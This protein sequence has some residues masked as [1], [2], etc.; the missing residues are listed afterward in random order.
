MEE[1]INPISATTNHN[2]NNSKDDDDDSTGDIS[3]SPPKSSATTIPSNSSYPLPAYLNFIPGG[4]EYKSSTDGSKNNEKD[5]YYSLSSCDMQA[6]IQRAVAA[7][8]QLFKMN[9]QQL[10]KQPDDNNDTKDVYYLPSLSILTE[11]V[12]GRLTG[13][14][15]AN[16][17]KWA[18]ALVLAYATVDGSHHCNNAVQWCR[19][20][21]SEKEVP[22]TTAR[23]RPCGYVFK[24]GDIAWNCRTC[25]ADNTCVICDE[26]FR[27]SDHEGHEVFFHRTQPGGCCD[28]G[29]IEA[30]DQ[31]G[32]CPQHSPAKTCIPVTNMEDEAVKASQMA[33][34]EG[35]EVVR[36]C[37][38]Q[39]MAGS[40]LGIVIGMA[41]QTIVEAMD[42]AGIGCD[43]IQWTKRW[44][45][46][47]RKIHDK[48]P[49][50]EDYF[51]TEQQPVA[52]SLASAK[53]LPL[54]QNYKLHLRLHNDDVHT[55]DEVIDALHPRNSSVGGG[56]PLVP[57]M[58]LAEELT[59]YVDSDGQVTVK[60]SF[61]SLEE[62]LDGFT[63]LRQRGL[64]CV[65][66]S[67]PQVD[68]ELRARM[69]VGWLSDL[70]QQHASLQALVI[71]AF[72]DVSEGSSP[73]G[74]I[75]VWTRAH[76]IPPWSSRH[77]AF[78]THL[79]TSYITRE[80]SFRLYTLGLTNPHQPTK[81]EFLYNTGT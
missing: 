60:S 39:T 69:L 64:Q 26:C 41:V 24:R 2:M 5:E 42:G 79:S 40:A 78:P 8:V 70:C 12:F 59:H 31:K 62:A 21:L 81:N 16:V 61:A 51:S 44:S 75:P 43:V 10:Q 14:S 77:G 7:D 73:Y 66:A 50:D 58:D 37:L 11:A 6:L 17:R 49:H 67:T 36:K 32:C 34:E 38:G 46:E 27:H 1:I 20:V 65:V 54:P 71:H 68:L 9:Q 30:W 55:F 53:N 45:D 19:E 29:D 4:M 76:M 57:S 35:Q 23:N 52:E 47:I 22:P 15:A 74:G 33:L 72:L 18:D 56:S 28:C 13:V 3:L 25:Q 80:E 63:Q 48:A